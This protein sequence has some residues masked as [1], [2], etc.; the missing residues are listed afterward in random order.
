MP[1]EYVYGK[2][3]QTEEANIS[4]SDGSLE[5]N[6]SPIHHFLTRYR[7]ALGYLLVTLLLIASFFTGFSIRPIAS[8]SNLP[9]GQFAL[10][11][12]IKE[13]GDTRAFLPQCRINISLPQDCN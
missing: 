2:L 1:R 3:D 11:N 5:L 8:A 4:D 7:S 12:G 10:D 9:D 13:E 6:R